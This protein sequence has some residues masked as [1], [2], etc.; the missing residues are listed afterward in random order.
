MGALCV[1]QRERMMK[2][3]NLDYIAR[4]GCRC[5][6]EEHPRGDWCRW[7]DVRWTDKAPTEEGWYWLKWHWIDGSRKEIVE[8]FKRPGHD[9]LAIMNPDVCNHTKRDFLA[10]VKIGGQWAGPIQQPPEDSDHD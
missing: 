7:D 6:M 9:Y 8:V 2:R 1:I 4:L 10:V 3:Y 5:K